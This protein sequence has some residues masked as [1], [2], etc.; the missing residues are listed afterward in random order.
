MLLTCLYCVVLWGTCND[1]VVM[2]RPLNIQH[3]CCMAAHCR[4]WLIDSA[5][6]W[7]KTKSYKLEA[8]KILIYCSSDDENSAETLLI[9]TTRKAPPPPASMITAMNFGLTAQRGLSHVT[10]DTLT[11]SMQCSA[12]HAW[13]KTCRNLL[14]LTTPRRKDISV[15]KNEK[16]VVVFTE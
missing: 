15:E 3:W 6:L 8:F 10:R 7:E 4:A 2:R 16:S 5:A 12:F 13:A 1:V 14:C 11:S 9:G